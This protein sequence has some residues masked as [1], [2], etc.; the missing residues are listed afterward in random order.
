MFDRD[1]LSRWLSDDRTSSADGRYS[2]RLLRERADGRDSVLADLRSVVARAH[3]DARR[4]LRELADISLDPLGEKAWD[5]AE[6][7]PERLNILTLQGYFGE[8]MAAIVAE[9]LPH[10]GLSKWAVPAFPFRFHHV[11]FDQ[12]EKYRQTGEEPSHVPGRT[13]NDML[14][15]LRE[16]DGRIS[17]S[18]VCEAKCS[19]NHAS[20]LI[21]SAHSQ[22]SDKLPKPVEILRI[23]DILREYD[24]EDS[25]SWVRALRVLYYH[26]ISSGYERCDLV[27]YVCG[28]PPIRRRAWIP[29]DRPHSKYTAGRRLEAVEIHLEHV[30]SLINEVYGVEVGVHGH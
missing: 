15:F 12:L 22:I 14:A 4:H 6:G 27:S 23:I 24:D 3:E 29:I 19:R 18:L 16:A 9:S 17:R 8:I 2:H 13:G 5:P 1:K 25:R 10:F 11:A 21:S 7:Y 28:Q 20:G 30:V 26:D